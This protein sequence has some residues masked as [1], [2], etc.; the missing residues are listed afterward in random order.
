MRAAVTVELPLY[1]HDDLSEAARRAGHSV[2]TRKRFQ[3]RHMD[4]NGVG[5]IHSQIQALTKLTTWEFVRRDA[6][7]GRNISSTKWMF[8]VKACLDGRV[9]LI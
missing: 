9:E 8:D 4:K 7:D 1:E 3:T 2:Y 5:D 6:I